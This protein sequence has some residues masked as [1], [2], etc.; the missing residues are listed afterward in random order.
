[1]RYFRIN[2]KDEDIYIHFF[3]RAWSI[4]WSGNKPNLLKELKVDPVEFVEKSNALFARYQIIIPKDFPKY[5][6]PEKTNHEKKVDDFPIFDFLICIHCCILLEEEYGIDS[7]K[8]LRRELVK[9]NSN[10][11]IHHACSIAVIALFYLKEGHDV[12]IPFEKKNELNPDLTI[13]NLK[14]E[15]K[16]IQESDW[17]SE[18]D[19]ATGFGKRKSRGPDLCY[20]LGTFIGKENS[21][22]KGILQGDMVFADLTLKSFGDL[23]SNIRGLGHGDKLKYGLPI[24]K[25]YRMIFFSR[26]NL[27]CVGYYIDFEPRLWTLIDIASG[28]E[29]QRATFSFNIPGDGKFHKIKL[30]TPP[31]DQKENYTSDN[32]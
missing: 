6:T 9:P 17:T 10:I 14:C 20:D 21:G 12:S 13:D 11:G 23:S 29:Y 25:K 26:H 30:P 32:S 19:P 4:F 27:D 18:I 2:K 16:T 1:M 8:L 28:I 22:Y 15:V 31:E 5:N 7:S 24:P 3:N